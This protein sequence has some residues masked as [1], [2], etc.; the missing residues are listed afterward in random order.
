MHPLFEEPIDPKDALL[1]NALQLAYIGDAV[2][3][4]MVRNALIRQGLTV[5]H[6]HSACIRHVNAHAQAGF[7]QSIFPALDEG[8]QELVRRGRNAHA[9]HPIPKN[10][11]PEDYSLATAFE[12]LIGF[13]FLTGR[14]ER[15]QELTEHMIGGK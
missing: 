5:H 12:A 8:E 14:E 4:L 15:I 13:L 1:M 11:N 10:Q 6:M 7:L 3:D 2:W 9:H